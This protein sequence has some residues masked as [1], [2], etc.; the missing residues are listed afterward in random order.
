MIQGSLFGNI[1]AILFYMLF[2]A[3]GIFMVWR[4][5]AKEQ[6]SAV[7][8]VCLGSVAGT[9]CFQWFPI[10]FAFLF[11]F[12]LL[13]HALA[14]ALQAV[15]CIAVAIKVKKSNGFPYKEHKERVALI[16]RN[17]LAFVLIIATALYFLYCLLTHTIPVAKDG[18]MTTGQGTYGDM[19]MHLGFI[20]SI[21][22]QQTFPP[23]Y[24][25][26]PGQKLSYPFL[27]DSISSSLYLMGASLRCA[28]I[29][30]MLV[31]I[32]QILCGFY[33]FMKNWLK[34]SAAATIS[35]VLFFVNGG[36][37]FVHF[38]NAE[39]LSKNFTDFYFTPTSLGDYNYRFAQIVVNMLI[40]QRATL[41]GWAVLFPLLGLV[42]YAWKKKS[43]KV[44][45][46]A[47]I[48]A[49]ALPMIHTHSFL[50]LGMVC[51]MWLLCDLCK[52][53]EKS[54]ALMLLMPVGVAVL[55]V[56]RRINDV[57]GWFEENGLYI[58]FFG[59][60]ILCL[61]LGR[62]IIKRISDNTW[63]SYLKTWGVF[64]IPVILFALPQLVYWTFGQATGEGFV[65]SHFNWSNSADDYIFFYL[66]N[67]G[68]PF[69]LFFPAW[70]TAKKE[71]R[72]VASP[73]LLI[74]FVAEFVV[75]Q[76]NEY[77]NNKLLFI[78]FF[79]LC[80]MVADYVVSLYEK[81]WNYPAK[82]AAGALLTVLCTVSA[83]LTMGREWVSKYTLYPSNEVAAC[84]Y[85]EENVEEDGVFLT[86]NNHNNAIAS[87][88]GRSIVCGSGSFLYYHGIDTR[89]REA[90]LRSMY[91]NPLGS[92][93]LF[94]KYNVSYIFIGNNEL[95]QYGIDT[96]GIRQIAD[97]IFDMNGVSLYAL[98]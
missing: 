32:M 86:A 59:I 89:E 36:L 57:N 19:N 39:N 69:I 50:A 62:Y 73:L 49:G 37:G 6:M 84:Y 27:S 4:L 78:A 9:L 98:R 11:D 41:F 67:I 5:L 1:S 74:F 38:L 35:F 47:G 79:F 26:F 34:K 91:E 25:L 81:K 45:A 76:P 88:T 43:T 12:T 2:I 58:V 68:V 17:P 44:F 66:K 75:F 97:C 80:G 55:D 23:E 71:K 7:Y 42:Y 48:F 83:I 16:K 13:S 29:V 31:A 28:Y 53:P 10:L 8:R 95:Q 90:D 24:S 51:V 82:I 21:A 40:P 22:K 96:E 64:L 61:T 3:S 60:F 56:V 52:S 77:D 18:S 65:R 93:E 15:L 70:I 87:L 72:E 20:T 63:K 33:C 14:L 85:V 46:I 94:D 54:T 30:P 92:A